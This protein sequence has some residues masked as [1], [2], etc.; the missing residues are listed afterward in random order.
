[1]DASRITRVPAGCHESLRVERAMSFSYAT[2]IDTIQLTPRLRRITLQ[3]D[4]PE[5]LQIKLGGDSAVGVY[6]PIVG[7]DGR[8]MPPPTLA[9]AHGG[10]YVDP[11]SGSEGRT[12]TVRAHEEVDGADRIDLDVVLHTRGPGTARGPLPPV[13]A[14][15]SGSTMPRR[16][17][18]PSRRATGNYW[19]P[20]CP[21]YPPP[22]ASS[23]NSPAAYPS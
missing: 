12:Y 22:P 3:V 14:T 7:R 13:L 20:T 23:P 6:F 17:I 16:G 1:L 2:V 19:S 15:G 18:G 9:G 10:R 8:R 11:H 4:D 5:A 21:G